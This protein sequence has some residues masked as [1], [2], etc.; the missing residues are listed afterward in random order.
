[1]LLAVLQALHQLIDGLDLIA[2]G[3]KLRNVKGILRGFHCGS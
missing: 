3:L 1:M 2:L